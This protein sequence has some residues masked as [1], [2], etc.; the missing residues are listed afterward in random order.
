MA[1]TI[2][3]QPVDVCARR[4]D[5]THENGIILKVVFTGGCGGNTQ[6]VSRLVEGRK[7]EEVIA[8]LDGIVC[9]GSR[10]RKTS[11][12]AQLANALKTIV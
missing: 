9:P 1:E 2:S 7:V 8:L 11:C 6:G 10:T 5:I 3:Y 12:P 4:I